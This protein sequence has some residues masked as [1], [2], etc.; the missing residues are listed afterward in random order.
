MEILILKL[1]GITLSMAC[2]N[3]RSLAKKWPITVAARSKV[4][5]SNSAQGMDACVFYSVFVLFCV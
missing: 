5:G 3:S 2:L 4:V 1:S